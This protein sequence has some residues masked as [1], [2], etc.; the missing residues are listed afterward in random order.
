MKEFFRSF[1]AALAT[2]VAPG[3]YGSNSS[4]SLGRMLKDG[5]QQEFNNYQIVKAT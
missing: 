3:L 4:A 5:T 2:S 1:G